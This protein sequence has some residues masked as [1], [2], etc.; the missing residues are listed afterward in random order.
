MDIVFTDGMKK[1]LRLF[2]WILRRKLKKKYKITLDNIIEDM[3]NCGNPV[4]GK[5]W[6]D[7]KK[8]CGQIKEEYQRK[9]VYEFSAIGLWMIYKDTAYGPLFMYII[10]PMLRNANEILPIAEK[11]YVD[12]KDLYVNAWSDSKEHT[13]QG[14]KDGKIPDIEGIMS[15]DEQIFVPQYQEKKISM[16]SK[17]YEQLEKEAEKKVLKWKPNMK[18][19]GDDDSK[20]T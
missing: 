11:Y 14:K 10:V 17:E 4:I 1:E 9:I 20:E 2:L 13:N 19:G 12:I 5:I 16:L 7:I 15:V 6:N 3:D 8:M 18:K